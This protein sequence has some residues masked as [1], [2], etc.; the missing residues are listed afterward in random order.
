MKLNYSP[1][2]INIDS[3]PYSSNM[4]EKI[5][6][7]LKFAVL[8]PSGHNSQPWEFKISSNILEIYSDKQ[9]SLEKSDP[10]HRQLMITIGCML[11][12]I[13]IA[14]D[15]YGLK[16]ELQIS[17]NILEKPIGKIIFSDSNSQIIKSENLK[18]IINRITN[19]GKYNTS[20]SIPESFISKIKSLETDNIN[21]DYISQ[22]EDIHKISET[23]IDFQI[24]AMDSSAFRLELSNF[25]KNNWTNSKTGM[26]AG[27]FGIPAPITF[28]GSKIIKNINI[29]KKTRNKDLDLIKN[30]TNGYLIIST[31]KESKINWINAGIIFEKI[32]LLATSENLSLAPNAA[33]IQFVEGR[34]SIQKIIKSNFIPSIISRIG[35]PKIKPKITPRL[36]VNDVL[37]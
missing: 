14:S 36:S 7:I 31:N 10:D 25:L 15:G 19:R 9:R 29:N 33:P 28:F 23:I 35:F 4:E 24:K 37:N 34:E 8:A 16:T 11:G 3:F 5:K 30:N 18:S 1:W 22:K 20:K 12:N 17:E 26:I 27:N 21:I 6:F 13:L 32:W 2:N